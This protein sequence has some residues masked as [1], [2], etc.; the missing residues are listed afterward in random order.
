MIL[1]SFAD[2]DP[3]GSTQDDWAAKYFTGPGSVNAFY[4]EASQ[5]QYGLNPA[6]ETSGTADNGVVG[7]IEL[8]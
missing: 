7:W 4:D 2:Q 6:T 3:V 8:P 5:G 1:V